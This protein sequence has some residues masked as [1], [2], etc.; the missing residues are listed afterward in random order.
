M[1]ELSPPAPPFSTDTQPISYPL[2]PVDDDYGDDDEE[3][4]NQAPKGLRVP[5][6]IALLALL[7]F[8]ACGIWGGAVLQRHHDN[9]TLNTRITAALATAVAGR[10]AAAGAGTGTGAAS[11]GGFGGFGGGG[12]G[13]G[14]RTSG[15]V[16]DVEG[17][18]VTLTDSAGNPIKV[19]LA[20]TTKITKTTAGS[21]ADLQ[22]GQTVVVSGTK[23]ADGS[24]TAATITI[25]GSPTAAP[26]GTATPGATGGTG[27]G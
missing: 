2:P 5:G 8:A 19:N 21:A 23:A 15:T 16:T 20:P 18:V 3:W 13:A 7:F 14:G 27:G 10:R 12:G 26:G 9:K 17:T 24:T 25:A 22:L 6:V 1:S 4:V 11:T